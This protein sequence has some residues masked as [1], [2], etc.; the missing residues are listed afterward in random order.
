M[1]P[2][3]PTSASGGKLAILI[4]LLTSPLHAEILVGKGATGSAFLKIPIAA[5]PTAMGGAFTAVSGDV[6]AMEYN[7]SG[8][9]QLER[10]DLKAS[11]IRYLE[12]SDL[13][14]LSVGFPVD[15]KPGAHL[16]EGFFGP[17]AD[18][19]FLGFHYR[20]FKADDTERNELGAP[21]HEFDIKD[22]LVQLDLAYAPFERLSLGVGG[23]YINSTLGRDSLTNMAFDMGGIW[24]LSA[25]T[26]VGA[27]LL[28]LGPDRAYVS[29]SDPLPTTLRTGFLYEGSLVLLTADLL[30]GRDKI[31]Q[32]ALGMEVRV[33]PYLKLR[34]GMTNHTSLEFSGGLGLRFSPPI[35]QLNSSEKEKQANQSILDDLNVP[36]SNPVYVQNKSNAPPP[37]DFGLDYAIRSHDQLDATHT[38]TISILY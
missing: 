16:G 23:K 38:I 21:I 13:Q 14:S 32:Q 3:R 15:F 20:A 35:P 33:N 11:L 37:I 17:D 7:P 19:L 29:E 8:I 6:S 28:N 22:Q 18:K 31:T 4:F 36:E 27:S 5:R 24:K 1:T 10:V 34:G 2:L 9:T 30:A 26:S 12:D 25:Q